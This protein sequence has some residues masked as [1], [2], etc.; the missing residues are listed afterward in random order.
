V[1]KVLSKGGRQVG[2]LIVGQKGIAAGQTFTLDQT[3]FSFGRTTDNRVVLS[4]GQVSRHHAEIRYERTGYT[5]YD[6]DSSNGTRVNGEFIRGPHPLQDRDIITISKNVFQIVAAPAV[7][8]PTNETYPRL[9]HLKPGEPAQTVFLTGIPL[10]IGRDTKNSVVIQGRQASRFH[11]VIRQ[12]PDGPAIVDLSSSNGTLVND[13]RIRQ[14]QLLQHNDR[15]EIGGETLVYL[16]GPVSEL[17]QPKLPAL[18]VPAPVSQPLPL[19]NNVVPAQQPQVAP[20]PPVPVGRL[21]PVPPPIA[22]DNHQ[23]P[24]H[25]EY[26]IK[27]PG[28]CGRTWPL[29]IEHCPL[30]GY[31]LANGQSVLLE[32]YNGPSAKAS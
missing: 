30:D 9:L 1:L 5:I 14:G 19:I 20:L 32:A 28:R 4:E 25:V 2:W 24:G 22:P 21:A 16:A 7:H 3:P 15:L 17:G 26:G 27:C 29:Y 6:L 10:T 12:T 18:P 31:L 23:Q 8:Q 13:E 11:A